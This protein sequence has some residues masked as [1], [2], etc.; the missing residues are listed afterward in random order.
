MSLQRVACSS[1]H[2]L[3]PF[4][5]CFYYVTLTNVYVQRPNH[6]FPCILNLIVLVTQSFL[7]N[8][9]HSSPSTINTGPGLAFIAYPQAAA[10]MPL[11]QFWNICFFLMLIS[12]CVDTHVRLIITLL[13]VSARRL[14]TLISHKSVHMI[15][16]VM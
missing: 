12:L 8:S 1:S 16:I 11:P 4:V 14:W 7:S 10:M 3:W 6:H 9:S 5:I 15:S 13:I 2:T